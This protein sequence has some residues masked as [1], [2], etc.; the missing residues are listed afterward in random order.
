MHDYNTIVGVI[1][2]RNDKVSYPVIRQRYGIGNSGIDLIMN[3]YKESGLPWKD[4]LK[5]E[6]SQIEE[7]I[8]PPKNIRKNDIPMPDFELYY[9]RMMT[10]GCRV[11]IK[12]RIDTLFQS[13]QVVGNSK[14]SGRTRLT[15]YIDR[16]NAL[17]PYSKESIII[18]CSEN[19]VVINNEH[20][21]IVVKKIDYKSFSGIVKNWVKCAYYLGIIFSKTTDDHLSYFLGVESE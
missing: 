19:K 6:P 11:N 2:L 7:L 18:L 3:R 8:Y 14:I 17:K 16:Y 10:K 13:E 12:S 20:K 9:E 15:G 4:F 1:S 21:L 5:L